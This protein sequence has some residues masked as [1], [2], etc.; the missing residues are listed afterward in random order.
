M[1]CV[2]T[3]KNWV[4]DHDG[5]QVEERRK[6]EAFLVHLGGHLG[7]DRALGRKVKGVKVLA[8]DLGPY[9]ETLVR[10]YRKLRAPDDTF[11]T[12]IARLSPE[13]F[14]SFSRQP[15]TWPVTRPAPTI[16]AEPRAS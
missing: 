1:G 14:H 2:L 10:R 3:E 8:S 5:N 13:D 4:V 9:V 11:A 7:R 12:F 16:V 6:V 15:A